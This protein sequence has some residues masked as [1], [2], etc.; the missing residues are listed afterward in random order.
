V[1]RAAGSSRATQAVRATC[2]PGAAPSYGEPSAQPP[3]RR[4]SGRW[5]TLAEGATILLE[6]VSPEGILA[7]LRGQPGTPQRPDE[8]AR[9]KLFGGGKRDLTRGLLALIREVRA[10]RARKYGK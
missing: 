6:L 9:A 5:P 3:R 8:A 1:T 4:G 10:A 7:M 2:T